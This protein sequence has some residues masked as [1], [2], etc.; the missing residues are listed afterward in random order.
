MD[1]LLGAIT[2]HQGRP[3]FAPVDR[4]AVAFGRLAAR[5]LHQSPRGCALATDES[6]G[7]AGNVSAMPAT[8]RYRP[9]KTIKIRGNERLSGPTLMAPI[10]LIIGPQKP[11]FCSENLPGLP[12]SRDDADELVDGPFDPEQY[13]LPRYS[14]PAA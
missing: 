2:A 12:G 11:V 8:P 13:S 9:L 7:R 5:L 4:W 6:T 14:G 10:T 3:P 1:G